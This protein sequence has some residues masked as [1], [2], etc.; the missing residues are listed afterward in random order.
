MSVKENF[1]IDYANTPFLDTSCT[2][3]NLHRLNWRCEILLSRNREVINGKKIL[4]L[5]SHDGRFTF[6]CL[7]LGAKHVTG[8]E[9]REY[10]IKSSIDNL[11]K[12]GYTSEKYYFIQGD[13]FDYI[14]NVKP[15]EFD[16]ILCLGFFDHTIRQIELLREFKRIQPNTLMLEMRV[17]RGFFLNIV[18]PLRYISRIKFRHFP[19][20]SDYV[21]KVQGKTGKACLV[22]IDESHEKEGSTIDPIDIAARPN[23]SFVELMFNTHRFSIKQLKWNKK[24]ISNR[25]DVREYLHNTRV[26]YIARPFE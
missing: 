15:K 20:I 24:E 19:R 12:M 4:D 11:T 9:G 1:T 16:T 22:F 25:G 2:G 3:A 14:T 10:L 17:E 23:R 8:I 13:V 5:G 18:N 6:A 7:K 26:C 21:D